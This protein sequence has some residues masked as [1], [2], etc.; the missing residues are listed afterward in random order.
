MI[1]K[2]SE[3]HPGKILHEIFEGNSGRCAVLECY[4]ESAQAIKEK[5]VVID[6]ITQGMN[7]P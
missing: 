5:L 4:L 1:E 6:F 3:I 7:N 2:W